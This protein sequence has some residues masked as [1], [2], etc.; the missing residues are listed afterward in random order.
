MKKSLLLMVGVM[1]LVNIAFAQRSTDIKTELMYPAAGS[2]LYKNVPFYIDL[3]ITNNGPDNIRR[4]DTMVYEYKLYGQNLLGPEY[5][6]IWDSIASGEEYIYTWNSFSMSFS[7]SGDNIPF[8]VIIHS[9]QNATSPIADPDGTN[10]TACNNVNLRMGTSIEENPG[11]TAFQLFPLPASDYLNVFF[12]GNISGNVEISVY[13]LSGHLVYVS[14]LGTIRKGQNEL[15]DVNTLPEGV[16][17]VEVKSEGN[18]YRKKAVIG[19]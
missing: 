8:C 6:R 18:I 19:R 5:L 4:Y 13:D 3:K 2:I 15:I 16:Y 17:F 12:S 1:L 11:A 10:N 14:S 9:L 7:T